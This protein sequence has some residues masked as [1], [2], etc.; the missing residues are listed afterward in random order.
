MSNQQPYSTAEEL[1]NVAS[2][3]LGLVLSIIALVIL[4]TFSISEGDALKTTSYAIYG[5]SL[6]LLFLASTLYHGFNDE[7]IKQ[8]F[9]LLDHCAIYILIA[10]SYTPLMLITL[11][12]NLGYSMLGVI[13]LIALF[14][15]AFK[16]KF[17]HKYKKLSVITYLGMGFISLAIINQLYLSLPVEGLALLAAG[18]LTYTLGVVFYLNKNIP[19]NHAIWHLFVLAGAGCH[20]VMMRYYLT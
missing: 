9:K 12:G 15:I 5:T 13:W 6:I 1:A 19:F 8:V 20:F 16:V 18:G 14:G 10:G 4:L 3:G 17:G 2:H 7:K 11:K